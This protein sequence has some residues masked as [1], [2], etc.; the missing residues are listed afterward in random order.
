M[1]ERIIQLNEY[2][3]MFVLLHLNTQLPSWLLY[4]VVFWY[5]GKDVV[6]CMSVH[7][8]LYADHFSVLLKN[9]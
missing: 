8:A 5:Q 2:V 9:L 4:D 7:F 6:L 3:R 1:I